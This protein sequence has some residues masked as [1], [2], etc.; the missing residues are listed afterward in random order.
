MN[1]AELHGVVF[2]HDGMFISYCLFFLDET[3]GGAWCNTAESC[4]ERKM[5]DLGSSHFMEAV[6]FDGILSNKHPQNP[7]T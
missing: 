1:M 5:T 7:G 4:S 2:L 3:Q 6:E